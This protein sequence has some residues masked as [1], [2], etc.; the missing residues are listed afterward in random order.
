MS[1]TKETVYIRACE[2]D[3]AV[4]L[5]AQY[6]EWIAVTNPMLIQPPPTSFTAAQAEQLI[7]I[8]IG[9]WAMHFIFVQIKK[10]IEM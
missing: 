10:V 5:P 3:P 7:V 6:C 9:Y 8:L 1:I 2:Q 4:N